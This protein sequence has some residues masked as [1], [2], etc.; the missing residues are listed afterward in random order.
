M[1]AGG[2]QLF[3]PGSCTS[4]ADHHVRR[5]A[6]TLGRHVSIDGVAGIAADVDDDGALI[7]LDGPTRHR[8]MAGEVA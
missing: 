7:V 4:R 3:E 5:L 2:R 1:V 6:D 8:L